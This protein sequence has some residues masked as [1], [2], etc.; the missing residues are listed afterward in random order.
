[1]N[2]DKKDVLALSEKDI[3]EEARD[4]LQLALDAESVNRPKAKEDLLFREGEG[5]WDKGHVVTSESQEKPE[6]VINFT[7]AMVRRVVNNMKQQRPR[8][9]CHPVGDGADIEIADI[10]NGIGRHIEYRSEAGVAYD[11]GG[12]MA[13]TMGWGYWR[14][15][16]EYVAPDS[17]EQDIRILPIQNPFTVYMDPGAIMPTAADADWCLISVK[18]KRTEFRRRYPRAE[19]AAWSDVGRDSK[20]VDWEDQE[21][22]RLAEYF[23]IR[24]KGEKLYLL[25]DTQGNEM[26]RFASEMP[27]AESLVAAGLAIVDDRISSRRTVEWFRLN[28]AKVVERNIIPGTYIPV[29]R[30]QGNAV[31]IDGEIRRRGM[32][33]SMQDPQRMVDYGETAKIKRLGLT[34]Q[35][36]WV[37]AEGQLDGHPEWINSNNETYAVLTYKP[38][39][40]STAQGDMVLPPPMRQPPAQLEQGFAEFTAGMRSNLLAIAGMPNEPGQDTTGEVVSGVAQR[41]RQQLSD[42]SHFQYYDN[43]TLAIAH[44]WRI[45]L[46]WIPHYYSTERMQRIIGEDG[47]PKMIK[48][49]ERV[50]DDGVSRIK[51]DLTI[52][53]YDVVMDT[54]PGYETKREEGAENLINLLGVAPLAELIAKVGADLVFRSID[55]PY[56]QELADR[57]AGMTPEGL[58]GILEQLPQRAQ[59]IVKALYA[60]LQQTQQALQAAQTEIKQGIQKEQIKAAV[61]VHDTQ[62]WA[63]VDM[64]NTDVKAHTELQ[65][66][67]IRAGASLLNTHTEAK[68]HEREAERMIAEAGKAESN[69]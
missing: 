12:E 36:P 27:A 52:G 30:C 10:I 67:E 15:V 19:N 34:P 50:Q 61:K 51:N 63:Q 57:I 48:I 8:G 38:V 23:R 25:R 55:H 60:E 17:F 64:R 2:D 62:T 21:E 69:K 28:G 49:N 18:M 59:A 3:F 33:R 20:S 46:E 9:K 22:I 5:H 56:M 40:V 45:M 7:D 42:Q 35:A 14:M 16:S 24:E 53:R 43:Q 47:V 65:K 6:L 68:Y 29:I 41:R 37:A 58:K 39:T 11:I 13:V 1:M 31:D 26:T 44:T 66:E 4:R 32:V 54:G